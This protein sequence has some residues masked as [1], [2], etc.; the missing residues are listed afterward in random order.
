MLL[1]IFPPYTSVCGVDLLFRITS[2]SSG[3][4]KN[5]INQAVEPD[6]KNS[7]RVTCPRNMY[8]LL[9]QRYNTLTCRL[10]KILTEPASHSRQIQKKISGLAAGE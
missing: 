9:S 10:G 5:F 8:H 4:A 1:P 2:W 6:V 3:F 7:K